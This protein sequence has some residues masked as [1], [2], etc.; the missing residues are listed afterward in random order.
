MSVRPSERATE[1]RW[2]PSRTKYRPE[3]SYTEIG[4]S[5]SPRRDA[6]A[7]RSQR[8]RERVVSGPEA[9]VEVLRAVDR[10]D[11]RVELDDLQAALALARAAERLHDL[12]EGQDQRDVVGL[13]PQPATEVRQDVRTPRT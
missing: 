9:A 7:I 2:W 1:T 5:D 6:A 13:A 8:M 3:I 12:L 4:G 10:A 11:D